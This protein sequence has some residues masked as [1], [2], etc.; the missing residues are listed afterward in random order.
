M[1]KTYFLLASF[2]PT[3][4][5]EKFYES[6]ILCEFLFT[7][8]EMLS[9]VVSVKLIFALWR[10]THA[11][12]MWCMNIKQKTTLLS[13]YSKCEWKKSWKGFF[14]LGK[15]IKCH[16]NWLSKRLIKELELS[17]YLWNLIYNGNANGNNNM[18]SVNSKCFVGLFLHA[19][20][21]REIVEK[22]SEIQKVPP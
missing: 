14:C 9:N 3:F 7:T 21:L 6:F 5:C 22:L 19:I 13:H 4:N 20:E 1:W 16:A 15:H 12:H 11:V 18:F 8:L 10:Y 17:H 2:L